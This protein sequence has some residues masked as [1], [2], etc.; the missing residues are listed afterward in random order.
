MFTPDRNAL[1]AILT[2]QRNTFLQ[3]SGGV[4]RTALNQIERF[5][6]LPH[7]VVITGLRRSGK[8]TLLRQTAAHCCQDSDF[9]Y[10][11]FE[12][13]RLLGFTAEGF[14]DLFETLAGLYGEKKTFLIDEIQNVSGFE[15]FVRRFQDNGYKFYITGSNANL[16]S[17]EIGTKLTGRHAD[18]KVTPFS[19][20]EYLAFRKIS[21]GSNNIYTTTDRALL[22]TAFDH[23]L[24]GG[25]MPEFVT[26]D[27]FDILTR[28]YEDV[29]IK[30][31]ALRYGLNNPLELRELY[32]Y[33]VTNFGSRFSYT[34]L[35]NSLG[36]GSVN[37]VKS[38]IHSLT[39][40]YFASLINKFDFSVRKQIM[41]EKKLYIAD[42]G[43][44]P[45]ISLKV[46]KDYGRLL[47]NLVH[48]ELAKAGIVSYFTDGKRECDFVL[49]E[50]GVVKGCYQVCWNITP[51][52][53][54]REYDG[55]V[56]ALEF[57]DFSEGIIFTSDQEYEV[58]YNGKQIKV[59]PVWKQ[60]LLN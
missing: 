52:N 34:R 33:L 12:D 57:F 19:F 39:E 17:R 42:N 54:E 18:V 51:E 30:D 35:K 41:N 29:V 31:I 32:Q 59:I 8:S 9:F 22:K 37:T 50:Q 4:Q 6:P 5:K 26:Y 15:R 38:Y 13:E 16:L 48:N 20:T 24:K 7:T 45:R 53:Q 49:Q 25:G 44:I 21:K 10:I 36:F 14:N 58:S 46:T 23:Y 27:D 11:N 2:E 40:T 1:A 56:A 28:T 47:E 43:F 55:I 3:R 60:L